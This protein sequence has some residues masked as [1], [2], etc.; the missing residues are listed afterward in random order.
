MYQFVKDVYNNYFQMLQTF[1]VK[2][3]GQYYMALP[4]FMIF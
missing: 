3:V 4:S 1:Y 2:L